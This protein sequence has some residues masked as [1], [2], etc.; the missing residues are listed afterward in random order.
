M[1]ISSINIE[2]S[3]TK[4]LDSQEILIPNNKQTNSVFIYGKN[5]SGK[6][7]IS[8]LFTLNNKCI[9]G[10]EYSEDIL[11]L[12]T[13]KSTKELNV[14]VNYDNGSSTVYT[15]NNI[16]NPI[17]IPTFNQ[18]YIDSKITYQVDFKNNKFKENNLNYGVELE[19]KTKYFEK[20]KEVKI[21]Q[22]KKEELEQKIQQKI[23]ESIENI[24]KDT[25]TK[26]NNKNY[27]L[28]T[29]E[30][31]KLI[32][33]KELPDIKELNN[34]RLEHIKYIQSLKDLNDSNK[35]HL[36][37]DFLNQN[38]SLEQDINNINRSLTFSEDEAKTSASRQ[39]LDNISDELKNWRLVGVSHIKDDECP[40]CGANIKENELVNMYKDYVNS[41]ISKMKS[42]LTNEKNKFEVY[43]HNMESSLEISKTKA[44]YL[45]SIFKTAIYSELDVIKN[46]LNTFFDEILNALSQKSLDQYLFV[47]SSKTIKNIDV[48]EIKSIKSTYDLLLEKINDINK[49]IDSSTSDKT[50]RNDDYFKSVALFLTYD[51]IK[52]EIGYVINSEIKIKQFI[53]ELKP[54][55]EEYENE[56]REKNI[57]LKKMNEI[58]DDF[59]ISNYRIDEEFDLCLNGE[60]VSFCVDK[61]LSNGEKSVIAFSLFISELELY[62]S[63]NEKNIIFIDDPISSV[64]YP[65]LYGIYNYINN[66]IEDNPT[67]QFIIS[68][69]NTLFMNLFK[70]DYPNKKASYFKMTEINGKT[71]MIIDNENL[72][73]IYLEKL[74]EIFKVYKTGIITNSQKLYIHNYCRYVLETI[75]RFEYPINDNESSSSKYYLNKIISN[76]ENHISDYEI[77]K[78]SLQSLMKIVNKGSHATI[79][80]VHDSEHFEDN[81]YIDSCTAIIKFIK[82]D[83]NGQYE[84]LSSD[85]DRM[86]QLNQTI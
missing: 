84:L 13:K 39:V 6:S 9:D 62:Y 52:D 63:E 46:K 71:K 77:S 59:N 66:L 29:L 40:F 69:H 85:Y 54:L 20:I 56:L 75:S 79:D 53:E 74:K 70:F 22:R 18:D 41:K 21:E 36:N 23:K 43:K 86:N 61:L 45:D 33:I 67:S 82:K 44:Q 5:G 31:L 19:S 7:S 27:A 25:A 37:I 35:I 73:S 60:K 14:K 3:F 55:K 58:L 50:K 64:D 81:H 32:D 78:V 68:S 10:K 76:I 26:D 30:K 28:F 65:N 83:Y 49:K 72:D 15:T 42:Y 24:K 1:K 12:K 34:K 17:R 38:S 4:F 80:E 16:T 57:L 11:Q 47:D 8:K 51:S 48:N 2:S